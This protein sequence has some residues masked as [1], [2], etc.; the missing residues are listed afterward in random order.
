MQLTTYV[1]QYY[2]SLMFAINLLHRMKL[3]NGRHVYT[4]VF[5]TIY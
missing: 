2:I 1:Y 4:N 5:F 3:V